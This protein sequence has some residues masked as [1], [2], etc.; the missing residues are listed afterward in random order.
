MIYGSS[1]N[2]GLWADAE[3]LGQAEKVHPYA[4]GDRKRAQSA[5][6]EGGGQSFA[7]AGTVDY[8]QRAPRGLPECP[9]SDAELK[10]KF[11]DLTEGLLPPEQIEQIVEK[12][13]DTGGACKMSPN[14]VVSLLHQIGELSHCVGM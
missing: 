2:P 8:Y 14:F 4:D 9:A 1:V 10:H 3:L 12:V 7:M 5:R 11:Y 13:D 6:R